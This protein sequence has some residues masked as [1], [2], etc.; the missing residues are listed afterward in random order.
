MSH[1]L[2]RRLMPWRLRIAVLLMIFGSFGAGGADRSDAVAAVEPGGPGILTKCRDWLVA[3]SCRTY[4]HIA[5]PSRIAVGDT[6]TLSFGSRPKEFGFPV[7][8]IA[9]KGR[10]CAI[11]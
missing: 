6:I 11:F 1:S 8:R 5:L 10:H 9:L 7:A 3:T 4:H 2:G